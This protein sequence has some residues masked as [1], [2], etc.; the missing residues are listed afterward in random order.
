[1]V[2]RVPV[3]LSP[4]RWSSADML[5]MGFAFGSATAVLFLPL[6][7]AALAIYDPSAA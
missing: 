1:M 4:P 2:L 7:C 5:A 3:I 6:E